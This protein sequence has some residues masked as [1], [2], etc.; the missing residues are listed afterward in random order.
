[1]NRNLKIISTLLLAVLVTACASVPQPLIG[2][3]SSFEPQ[4]ADQVAQDQSIRWG[5]VIIA[6]NPAQ[7]YSCLEVLGKRMSDRQRPI[8]ENGTIGRF[9]V[10]KNQ[11]LDPENF[12][13]GREVTVA[14][15]IKQ[16]EDRLV[17][18]LVYGYPVVDASTIYLWAKRKQQDS[19]FTGRDSY[20]S[21]GNP[22]TSGTVSGPN[23]E[24]NRLSN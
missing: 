20:W 1:M 14:G 18:G 3:Y 2:E 24:V 22:Y 12:A 17:D 21:F 13:I 19:Y 16:I 9:I 7:E 8:N 11:F 6:I 23:Y 5:G 15:A 4:Q 10:C